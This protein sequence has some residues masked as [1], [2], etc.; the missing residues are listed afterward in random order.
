[1][2]K[3][4]DR[5]GPIHKAIVDWLRLVLPGAITHHNRNEI[6]KRGGLIAKELAEA[7]RRGVVK[8]FPDILVLPWAHVGPML[9]EVKAP[10]NYADATQKAL[11]A[12]LEA[13]GYR[14]AVVRSIDDVRAALQAWGVATK[15]AGAMVDLPLRGVINGNERK[16]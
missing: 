15:E 1:M 10:G 13:L 7:S 4:I 11:H 5:E 16:M 3:R 12:R 8:G 2:A 6:N 9:F 14:V